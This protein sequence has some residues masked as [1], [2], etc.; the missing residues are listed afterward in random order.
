MNK[1]HFDVLIIGAGISGIG[2]AYHLQTKSPN[3]TFA[4]L[5]G[6]DGIGGTWD[7][8]KYPGI[9]SDSDMYTLGYAF[10]PWTE[11]KAI[12]DGPSIMKYLHE[13]ADE[14]DIKK[15]IRFHHMVKSAAWST[16]T[17]SWTLQVER[18]GEP[19][20]LSCNFL[21][22]CGGYYKYASGYTPDFAG[23]DRFEGQTIHPQFWPEDLDYKNK[24][25]VVIGS[26]ATAVTIVPEI[27]KDAGHVVMLQRS[28]TYMGARP[29][30]D[31]L[32][33]SIRKYLPAKLA[34]QAI[35]WRNVL[36]GMYFFNR[37]RSK[38]K[39]VGEFLVKNVREK[40]KPGYDVETHF[41]PHY[42]P[43][44]QRICAVTDDDLFNVINDGSASVVTD[45]IETFTEKGIKLKSGAELEADI[46]VT[47]TGLNL[48]VFNGLDL[49]VDGK[50]VVA[51]ETMAY[52]GMMYADVPNLASSFGYTNASWT[53]K[54]DLTCEYVC[55]VLNHME[56]TGTRQCT[57]RKNDASIKEVPWLDFSSGYVQRSIDMFPKQGD[58]KPWKLNQNYFLDLM[59]LKHASVDDGVMEFANPP[60]TAKAAVKAPVVEAAE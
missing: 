44:D 51:P 8:F 1:E 53:L 45:H 47:A 26:G 40:L 18:G 48:E 42:N 21:F 52:K 49:T 23:M 38:P 9:R 60:E 10:K 56:E 58:Q 37:A 33:I 57:P 30:I 31:K 41:T 14:N 54:C 29:A 22:L 3:R 20:E 7:L 6:R 32:A 12:A 17:S 28:P 35:R 39:Q 36:F 34:Y 16:D 55:R 46:I 59:S 27:A 24:R 11:Q 25:V 2:A 15:H 5:E 19:V 43:W 4:I 50:P 13:A